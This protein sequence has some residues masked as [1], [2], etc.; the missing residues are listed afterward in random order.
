M[1]K[2]PDVYFPT[3]D[4]RDVAIAHVQ[5]S[6]LPEAVGHRHLIVSSTEFIP[7]TLWA[8]ILSDEFAQKG[9]KIP[10]ELDENTEQIPPGKNSRINDY[11]MRH[12]L[13]IQPTSFKSTILDM[14]YSFIQ[15]G[16]VKPK[17]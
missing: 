12:V 11:R 17:F 3:C 9:F 14:A 7:M 5:A 15:N 6:I 10:T 8:E 2:V 16:I 1:E 13:K 4:V